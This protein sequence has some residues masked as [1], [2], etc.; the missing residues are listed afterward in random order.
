M[1]IAIMLYYSL[2]KI[3]N[4]AGR[5]SKRIILAFTAHASSRVP[6]SYRDPLYQYYNCDFSG[7][8]YMIN[9]HSLISNVFRSSNKEVAEY[10]ALASFRNFAEYRVTKDAGLDLLHSPVDEDTINKNRLLRIDKGKIRFYYEEDTTR[11][12][13]LWQD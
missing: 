1:D 11:R 3:L 4:K 2:R 5:S 13:K 6:K 7:D 12:N 8:S 10:I 9:P